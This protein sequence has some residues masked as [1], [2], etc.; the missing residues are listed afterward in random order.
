MNSIRKV[1]FVSPGWTTWQHRLM[2]GALRDADAHPRIL[3]RAFAPAQDLEATARELENWRAEGVY[4]VLEY[5]DVNRL[6]GALQRR[7]PLVNSALDDQHPGVVQVIRE[8][9]AVG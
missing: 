1:A 8:F 4:G 2:A 7:L 5:D 3:F 6:L 9:T